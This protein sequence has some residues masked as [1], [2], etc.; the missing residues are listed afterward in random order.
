MGKSIIFNQ[1]TGMEQVIGNWPGK[2]VERAMGTLTHHNKRIALIDLPGIYSLSTYSMEELVTRDYISIS[3]PH[4]VINVLDATA[5]ERNL[6][7][8]LQLLEMDAP[9]VVALN[10]MDIAKKKGIKIDH[11]KL[12][13]L[14]GCPVM[15]TV[16][17]KGKGLH[18]LIDKSIDYAKKRGRRKKSDI[19]YGMEVEERISKLLTE[20]EKIDLPY[21][22]RW[23]AIKL[24]EK[25][26]NIIKLVRKTEPGI[27]KK[28]NK[29][30][31]ELKDIHGEKSS[32]VISSERYTVA[33]KFSSEVQEITK[34][35]RL[36]FNERLDFIIMHRVW[37]YFLMFI[38]LLGVLIFITIVGDRISV[39]IENFF[40]SFRFEQ[41]GFWA[42]LLWNGGMV[43]FY[44]ALGV[45]LGFIL[46]F[47][48]LLG[49]IEDSGYIPRIAFLMDSPFH[50]IGLH[51]K[52][53]MPLLLGFGCSVPACAGC[54]IMD[55]PREKFISAFL[56][57]LVPCSARTVVILG[58]VG[59]YMGLHYAVI[60]Y[61]I[62][63]LLIIALGWALNKKMPGAHIGLIM[64]VPK[65]RVPS[66]KV[67]LKQSWVRFR[68]FVYLAIPLI[69][70]GSIIIE[71]MYLTG[72]LDT[73]SDAMSPVTVV[74][75]GLPAFTG[76]LLIFGFLRKEAALVLMAT[77]AG[78]TNFATVMT[79]EQMFV[80][81]LV[82]TLYVPCLATI[83]V[84]AKDLGWKNAL[85]ITF[86]EIG[87][88]L[89]LGGIAMRIISPFV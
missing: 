65:F 20:L 77:V 54:R 87:L 41:E 13:K 89:L 58:L 66:T 16:A 21:P 84:L 11:K 17:I 32:I 44:A 76:I 29:L 7:L 82:I 10:Q 40:E 45:A 68:E 34:G 15:P 50:K 2:T 74:W 64:E 39:G 60:L 81:A 59:A 43:G 63:F 18:E 28:A 26:S 73:V 9:V 49:A 57:T 67:V 51:G 36:S 86:A 33:S 53:C 85:T 52:A 71:A 24:L 5:L 88:A 8:T 75:L 78:T 30:A 42:E 19:R 1:L 80:F 12:E 4:V 23:L 6:F 27:I 61:I 55:S 25:D 37:G 31:R 70:V 62:D 56:A 35:S 79:P 72:V 38:V 48:L 14:L 3:K 83:T 46:P 22:S 47:Y 69:V